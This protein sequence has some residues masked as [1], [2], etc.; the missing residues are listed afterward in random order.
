MKKGSGAFSED[1]QGSSALHEDV[2][3]SANVLLELGRVPAVTPKNTAGSQDISR[4]E[5]QLHPKRTYDQMQTPYESPH[6]AYRASADE[7]RERL[8]RRNRAE[9]SFSG[10]KFMH[11][12]QAMQSHRNNSNYTVVLLVRFATKILGLMCQRFDIAVKTCKEIQRTELQ[13]KTM[14]ESCQ[15]LF[16]CTMVYPSGVSTENRAGQKYKSLA[17]QEATV[18]GLLHHAL[19]AACENIPFEMFCP[20]ENITRHNIKEVSVFDS[21][22]PLLHWVWVLV[23][24][25]KKAELSPKKR[26]S[27]GHRA[28]LHERISRSQVGWRDGTWRLRS[29][30]EIR[31]FGSLQNF[32]SNTTS[33]N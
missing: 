13:L 21:V 10:E 29:F 23:L 17:H 18:P 2:D 31:F 27:S 15:T 30:P 4:V 26:T 22:L 33:D 19:K 11:S 28:A 12:I 32:S 25:D 14:G 9:D 3:A 7:L 20:A 16:E 5:D 8:H 24:R 6:H 1:D